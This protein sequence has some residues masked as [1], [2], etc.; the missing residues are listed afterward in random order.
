MRCF[1]SLVYLWGIHFDIVLDVMPHL[2]FFAVP[3]DVNDYSTFFFLDSQD[4]IFVISENMN[5]VTKQGNL[6]CI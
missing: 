5:Y 1:F 3:I 6:Y 2:E 4:K